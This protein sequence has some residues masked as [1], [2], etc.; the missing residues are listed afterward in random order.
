L[1]RIPDVY[2]TDE[3]STATRLLAL[4]GENTVLDGREKRGFRDILDG[5]SNTIL[6]VKAGPEKAVP[7]T[8]PDDI[9]W[10]PQNPLASLGTINGAG[11][12]AA[13]VDGRVVEVSKNVDADTLRWLVDPNDMHAITEDY[14]VR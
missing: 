4:Q 11:F 1:D 8:K 13:F 3:D 9:A 7:W 5:T 2:R 10:D 6:F 12:L 14:L